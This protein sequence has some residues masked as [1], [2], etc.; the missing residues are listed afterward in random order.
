MPN[1]PGWRDSGSSPSLPPPHLR[2]ARGRCDP[3]TSRSVSCAAAP[4]GCPFPGDRASSGRGG[5]AGH[6]GRKAGGRDPARRR[7]RLR[8][9]SL[10]PT[11]CRHRPR[12][13]KSRGG[14]GH[15][16]RRG[17]GHCSAL[18][19]CRKYASAH[20]ASCGRAGPPPLPAFRPLPRSAACRW[21][22][23]VAAIRNRASWRARALRSSRLRLTARRAV[24][25]RRSAVGRQLHRGSG[26]RL[27]DSDALSRAALHYGASPALH[28]ES[29]DDE[30]GLENGVCCGADGRRRKCRNFDPGLRQG[31]E[32]REQGARAEAQP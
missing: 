9:G 32:G 16:Q 8:R 10:V 2:P 4:S 15:R 27:N 5:A 18:R 30:D 3:A 1:I 24:F 13:Q 19:A 12:T 26:V 7:S 6:T 17:N 23:W 21:L 20:R 28:Q 14:R 25:N 31:Q 29:F 11:R 22:P